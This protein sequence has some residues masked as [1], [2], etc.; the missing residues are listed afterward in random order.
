MINH[1]TTDHIIVLHTT[2]IKLIGLG[3]PWSFCSFFFS[4]NTAPAII[5]SSVAFVEF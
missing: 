5:L 3:G 1:Q 2:R 4:D